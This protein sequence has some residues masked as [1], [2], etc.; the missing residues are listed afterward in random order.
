MVLQHHK[1]RHRRLYCP[2][3][4][5]N[6]WKPVGLSTS[7]IRKSFYG[8][9]SHLHSI[10]HTPW[11]NEL[12]FSL[13]SPPRW[14]ISGYRPS[15]LSRLPF[16]CPFSLIIFWFDNYYSKIKITTFFNLFRKTPSPWY[17]GILY[18]ATSWLPKSLNRF[19]RPDFLMK[20][21]A[22]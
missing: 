9:S 16:S 7:Q 18:I 14:C 8:Y 4:Y 1:T 12:A 3:R 13:H 21:D 15:V 20:F 17:S 5:W 10:Y 2:R 6:T 19:R 11:R 22:F